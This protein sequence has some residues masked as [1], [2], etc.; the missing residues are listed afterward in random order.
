MIVRIALTVEIRTS[1]ANNAPENQLSTVSF[2]LPV[3]QTVQSLLKKSVLPDSEFLM[4]V[5]IVKPLV[6]AS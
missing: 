6:N 2:V 4:F 5:M 1:V 3:I